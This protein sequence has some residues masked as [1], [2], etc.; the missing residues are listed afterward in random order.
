MA[1]PKTLK[2][3]TA[4]VDGFG[5]VGRLTGGTPPKLALKVEEFRDG[6]M[7]AA[8]ELD[9]GTEKQEM[10]L[11]FAEQDAQLYGLWGILTGDKG[12]TLLGSQETEDGTV[13]A[14]EYTTR[15]VFKEMDAG[16]WKGSESGKAELKAAQTVRYFKL[17]I[18]GQDVVEIDAVNTIR[19]VGGV[20]QLAARRAA[21][22][23]S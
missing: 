20:D 10:V 21:L 23:L 5:Y 6:G 16:E 12:I 17:Q 3:F 1:L 18:A 4:F 22:G 8:I 13:E 7:D 9:M 2:G 14:I 19:K 15:G 11:T